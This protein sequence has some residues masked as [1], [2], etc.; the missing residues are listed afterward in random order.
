[1]IG[2]QYNLKEAPLPNYVQRTEWNVQDTERHRFLYP[3]QGCLGP[4]R[5]CFSDST[6]IRSSIRCEF[7]NRAAE[8]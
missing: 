5:G 4:C 1:V 3:Q 8:A 2:G 6:R 7:L